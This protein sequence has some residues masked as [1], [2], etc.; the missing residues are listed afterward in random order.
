MCGYYGYARCTYFLPYFYETLR[1]Y[2]TL[3]DNWVFFAFAERGA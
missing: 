1:R 2:E 3:C